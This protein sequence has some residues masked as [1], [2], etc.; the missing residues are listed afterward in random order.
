MTFKEY[1][2]KVTINFNDKRVIKKTENL[3]KKAQNIKLQ[4]YGQYL[5]IKKN[6]IEVK[7]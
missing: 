4:D 5:M 2:S 3:L 7:N 1:I 6:L